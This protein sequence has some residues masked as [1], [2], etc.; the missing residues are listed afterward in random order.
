[1]KARLYQI[2]LRSAGGNRL[3]RADGNASLLEIL[4]EAGCRLTAPCGGNGVCGQCRVRVS[5]P[6]RSRGG[7]ELVYHDELL[8]SCRYF[9]AGDLDVTLPDE[10]P[11]SILADSAVIPAGTDGYGLAVD[12]GTTTVA[13][14][15]YD[16][17]TG[18][19]LHARGEMNAQRAWGSDVI[20]RI[21]HAASAEGLARMCGTI[22]AQVKDMARSLCGSLESIRWVSIAGNTVMEH[23]FAGLSP[24]GIG[25]APFTPLSLFGRETPAADMLDGFASDAVIYLCPAAAGYVGGD[26]TAGLASSGLDERDGKTLFIDIGTN[27]EMVLGGR[28]GL[29]CCAAAAGPAFEGAGIACGSP[30]RTGA[31]NR[32]ETDLSYTVLGGGVPQSICGSGVLDAMAALLRQGKIDETGRMDGSECYIGGSVYLSARDVRQIQLAK[33]AVRAGIETLAEVSGTRME[34]IDEVVLAGG[35]GARLRVRSACAIGLLPPV[36]MDRVRCVGN[37]AGKGA[38]LAL[39]AQGRRRIERVQKLCRYEELSALPM[40]RDKFIDAMTF[41]EWEDVDG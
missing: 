29:I 24:R 38:A 30:A 18:K 21:Q 25:V 4:R 1:M 32:V 14:Y 26:I 7:D 12:I 27:G 15:L 41:E 28:Q 3:L 31:I 37:S 2:S 39:T 5:G 8:P 17:R 20:S 9:P 6:C 11:A 40:F 34:D 10:S 13:A 33:A 16:L 23:I 35:F 22:R 36:L 19:C